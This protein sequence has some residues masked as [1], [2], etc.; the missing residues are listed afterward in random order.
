MEVGSI[1]DTLLDLEPASGLLGSLHLLQQ[2]LN[3][4]SSS[5]SGHHH[6][7]SRRQSSLEHVLGMSSDHSGLPPIPSSHRPRSHHQ[8]HNSNPNVSYSR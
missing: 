7:T 8:R 3:N 2:S 5:S 1:R 6:H 4:N